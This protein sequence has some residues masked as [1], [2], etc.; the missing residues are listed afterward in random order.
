[1][2]RKLENSKYELTEKGRGQAEEMFG[3]RPRGAETVGETIEQID[4]LVS[5]IEG[6]RRKSPDEFAPYAARL[7]GL[8]DRVSRLAG[9]EPTG[10]R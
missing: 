3:K 4:G 6:T 10:R 9:E 8:A 1:M 7:R 5:F 2:A